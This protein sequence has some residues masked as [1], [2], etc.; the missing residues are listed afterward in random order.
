MK[1]EL[2]SK[3]I[4]VGSYETLN[5]EELISAI[6]RHSTI[7]EDQG[8]LIR[9]LMN[10]K[11][12]SPLQFV[13]FGFKIETSRAISAQIFRHRS[14]NAQEWSQR[15]SESGSIETI[16]FREEHEK[17]RQSS[18]EWIGGIVETTSLDPKRLIPETFSCKSPEQEKAILRATESLED[19]L[20]AYQMLLDSGVA[21]ECARMILPMSSKTI[22]HIDGTL[23]DLLS[24]LNV[25]LDHHAQKEVRDIALKIGEAL[26]EELPLVFEQIDWKNGMFL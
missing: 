10:N 1:T 9:Y 16:D 20:E 12:W 11:H 19:I 21:K 14:L 6:A 8:K 2:I 5:Q 22:I 17:N 18:S 3:T 13:S 25:R 26:A 15:Y 24:F 4:G 7:K 23:R